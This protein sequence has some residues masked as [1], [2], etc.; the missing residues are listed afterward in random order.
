MIS[1]LVTGCAS[2]R[3]RPNSLTVTI[4]P[5]TITPGAIIEVTV[6]STVAL[7]KLTGKINR[8]G[9]PTIALKSITS[10]QWT[11]K[12]QVPLEVAIEA[13]RY[14]LIFEG[15]TFND[16]SIFGEAWVEAP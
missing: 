2:L 8:L 10:T 3:P 4:Q 12:T 5:E 7:E 9:S 13:G 11:W 15:K 16:E 6:L 14:Q 1:M